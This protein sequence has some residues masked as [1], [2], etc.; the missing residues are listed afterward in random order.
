MEE[1][2]VK[3]RKQIIYTRSLNKLLNSVSLALIRHINILT[4]FPK[5][6]KKNIP[7]YLLT[8]KTLML[9]KIEG[10]R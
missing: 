7:Y 9:G 4:L 3:P 1:G 6:F 8:G 5:G 2:T 10:K